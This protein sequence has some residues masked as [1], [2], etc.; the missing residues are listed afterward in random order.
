MVQ[1]ILAKVQPFSIK[2]YGLD[3]LGKR[4]GEFSGFLYCSDPLIFT[5]GHAYEFGK[6]SSSS[7]AV[8]F[9]AVYDGGMEEALFIEAL[10]LPGTDAMLL[11]G[12]KAGATLYATNASRADVVYILGFRLG[13]HE[14]S[15]D[16]GMVSS[17][18]IG[19][20]FVTAHADVGQ[21]GGHVSV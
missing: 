14:L 19:A 20:W 8:S 12:S 2:V 5:S 18:S 7:G 1:S 13:S 9:T 17:S 6:S 11:R 10:P 3:G 15:I 16:K 21:L 4:C